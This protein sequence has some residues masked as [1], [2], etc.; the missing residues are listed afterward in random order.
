MTKFTWILLITA[1]SYLPNVAAQTLTE[2][3]AT[4]SITG[5]ITYNN[6]PVSGV[7]VVLEDSGVN[8]IMQNSQRRPVSAKTDTDGRYRLVGIPAGQYLVS[9]RA[10]AYVLPTED[11][12]RRVGK[13]VT[14]KDGEQIEDLDFAL[15]KGGVITGKVTDHLDR[16]VIAQR[17]NLRRAGAISRV[18]SVPVSPSN[19]FMFETDDC[20]IYRLYGLPAG[21]YTLSVG[22]DKGFVIVKRTDKNYPLTF[23]PGVSNEEAAKV[24]EV[25]EGSEASEINIKL[26][27]IEKNYQAR[28]RVIDVSTGAP[29][30]NIALAYRRLGD[31]LTLMDT[32]RTHERTNAQGE[33]TL[34]GLVP[35]RYTATLEL[36]GAANAYYSDPITFEIQESDTEGLEIKASRGASISGVIVIEGTIDPAIIK[37]V[38]NVGVFAHPASPSASVQIPTFIDGRTTSP[39]GTFRTAGIRPGKVRLGARVL[40][41]D[42]ALRMSR[43]ERDGAEIPFTFELGADEQITGIKI[44]MAYVSGVIRGQVVVVNGTLPLDVQYLVSAQQT[45]AAVRSSPRSAP[46]DMRGK[47]VLEGLTPGEYELVL[48][49]NPRNGSPAY[50]SP[51]PVRQMVTVGAGET[52]VTLTLDLSEKGNQ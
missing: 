14:L 37:Q 22:G 52:P 19:L 34:Q 43:L 38:V 36:L 32:R 27:K 13:N 3:P 30:S 2:K 47:F 50:S 17:V 16:P 23:F 15:V 28:G 46:V 24:I 26:P 11:S 10:L 40:G 4:A 51:H 18:A 35:G 42:V 31:D 1:L 48:S 49:P 9:P 45:N 41:G 12:T 7:T 20:G 29:L 6:Q 44:V 8:G 5:R 25:T 33:F 39:D 21:R